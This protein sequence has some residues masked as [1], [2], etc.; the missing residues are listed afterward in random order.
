MSNSQTPHS[1]K[2]RM[3]A[4]NRA[5]KRQVAAGAYRLSVLLPPETAA[6]L[7]K[8]V[9]RYGSRRQAVIAAL[10]SLPNDPA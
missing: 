4:A 2:C 10:E 1:R 3:D 7:D 6:K 9:R 5:V 8:L